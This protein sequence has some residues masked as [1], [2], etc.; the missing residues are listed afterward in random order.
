MAAPYGQ[1]I[2]YELMTT[3][4]AAAE[5]FYRKVVGWDAAPAGVEGMAYTRFS[6]GGSPVAGLM[7]LPEEASRAGGR[8]GW[9]GSVAVE[10]VDAMAGRVTQSGGTVLRSPAD[11][12]GIG[13][14]AVVADPHG[15]AFLLFAPGPP[16]DDCG[17]P[18][19]GGGTPGHVGWRELHAGDRETAFAFYSGLFGWTAA[20]A[21][22]LGPM[23]IYQLF[24][25]G[26]DF[27]VGGM[28]TK[29][30]QMPAPPTWLYYFNVDGVDAAAAR[31][32]EAGGQVINGPHQ[33]PGGSWILHG[34]DPQ[35]A[36]FALVG[37]AR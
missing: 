9:I 37:M 6:V 17:P 22:D 25:T 16:S 27:A 7:E 28:M 8:P 19:P 14:F 1:F 21:I 35:G 18:P 2:W 3:D 32:T 12:P 29:P 11:I 20:E 23:G 24:A 5:A 33:V 36:A 34:L 10:D 31:V 13:R 15:A 4:V 26:T 30:P